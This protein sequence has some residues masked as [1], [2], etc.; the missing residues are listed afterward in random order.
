MYIF[1]LQQNIIYKNIGEGIKGIFREE[2][3]PSHDTKRKTVDLM[4][5]VCRWETDGRVGP[6]IELSVT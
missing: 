4:G 3:S 5:R 2:R 6:R 1:L